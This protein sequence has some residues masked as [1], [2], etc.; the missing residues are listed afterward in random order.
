M[1]AG[2]RPHGWTPGGTSQDATRRRPTCSEPRA[3]RRCLWV[4]EASRGFER[5][6]SNNGQPR[7]ALAHT[8]HARRVRTGASS[9]WLRGCAPFGLASGRT[10]RPSCVGGPAPRRGRSRRALPRSPARP[11]HRHPRS[12]EAAPRVRR[13][14]PPQHKRERPL[15]DL[16]S[17]F[18]PRTLS[19]WTPKIRPRAPG[20]RRDDARAT[21]AER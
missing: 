14:R 19:S 9:T 3:Q 21:T 12:E 5:I 17:L 4:G 7:I 13:K 2:G 1:P 6:A 10:R 20:H 15:R 8:A 11:R 16:G 18:L